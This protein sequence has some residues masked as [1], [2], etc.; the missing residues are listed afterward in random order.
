MV[1]QP[2]PHC[3]RFAV[4]CE[5]FDRFEAETICI[6][7]RDAGIDAYATGSDSAQA[8]AMGGAGT[9]RLPR[10]EVPEHEFEQARRLLAADR[11]KA[12][13]ARR[14]KCPR[15]DE[16]NEKTF[17]VCWS[18]GK[19]LDE[20]AIFAWDEDSRE[21][22]KTPAGPW[23]IASGDPLPQDDQ[24]PYRPALPRQDSRGDE[25]LVADARNADEGKA[26]R[27]AFNDDVRRALWSAVIGFLILPPLPNLYSLFLL[28]RLPSTAYSSP[29]LRRRTIAAYLLDIGALIIWPTIYLSL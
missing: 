11:A 17:E 24:N 12:A 6:R 16:V 26:A 18:C 9:N 27:E 19:L 14:W 3:N 7:L 2:A 22:E 4:V 25:T 8:L 23:T 5:C 28:F 13:T 10:V 21:T 15:C 20:K 1:R 29:R